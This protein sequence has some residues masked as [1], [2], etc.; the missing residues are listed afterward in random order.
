MLS[1]R[2]LLD[3]CGPF[4]RERED[5]VPDE[6]LGVLRQRGAS[7]LGDDVDDFAD[8]LDNLALDGGELGRGVRGIDEGALAGV[9]LAERGDEVTQDDNLVVEMCGGVLCRWSTRTSAK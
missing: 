4:R 9:V 3:G 5:R 1:K 6:S 8:R 7:I 2:A